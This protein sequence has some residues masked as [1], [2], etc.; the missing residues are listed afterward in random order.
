MDGLDGSPEEKDDPARRHGNHH[1]TDLVPLQSPHSQRFV[2]ILRRRS[3]SRGTR[4]SNLWLITSVGS[5]TVKTI[6]DF[7]QYSNK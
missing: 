5:G 7:N 2:F 3:H 1:P 4:I 6:I